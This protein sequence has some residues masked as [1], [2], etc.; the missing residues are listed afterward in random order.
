[1]TPVDQAAIDPVTL[2]VAVEVSARAA[3]D[4]LRA[5]SSEPEL[6]ARWE[7]L[8]EYTQQYYRDLARAILT[9]S[10]ST[11]AAGSERYWRVA[12][13]HQVLT[14]VD[15]HPGSSSV[16]RAVRRALRAAASR[17]DPLTPAGALQVLVDQAAAGD[18][19][20]AEILAAV[21]QHG[22]TDGHS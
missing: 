4:D 14:E 9:A 15:R 18:A 5:R 2:E 17:L 19:G 16:K 10:A 3:V 1:M 6:M 13:A 11:V 21:N 22:G 20:A 12:L 7:E 8:T